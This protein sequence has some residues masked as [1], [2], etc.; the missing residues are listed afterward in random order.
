MIWADPADTNQEIEM[1]QQ[2]NQQGD[3]GGEGYVKSFFVVRV[4]CARGVTWIIDR[5]IQ[6]QG[7]I[8]W[9][10]ECIRTCIIQMTIQMTS[11]INTYASFFDVVDFSVTGASCRTGLGK[12]TE[13]TTV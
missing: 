13:G 4:G 8:T 6:I 7:R 10:V 2:G 5:V 1:Q 3:E 12:A 11:T 9:G